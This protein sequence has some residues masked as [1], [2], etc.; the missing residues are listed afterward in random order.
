MPDSFLESSSTSWFGRIGGAIKGMIFGLILLPVSVILLFWNETRAVT[1]A[2]S[3]KEGA[4]AVVSV[5]PDAI[6][7]Q[8][9]QKLIHLSGEVTSGEAVRDPLFGLNAPALRLARHV[10]MYQWKQEEHTEKHKTLGGGEE[11]QTTYNYTKVWSDRPVESAHF[12]HPEEHTNPAA[13]PIPKLTAVTAKA[14]LGAFKIP[15]P[16]IEKM[17]GDEP[18]PATEESLAKLPPPW[19]SKAKLSGDSVYLGSDPNAP[20][21]G[22]ARITFLLLKPGTFSIL[23]QQTGDALAPYP[24]HA[25]REIEDVESGTVSADVMF[26]HDQS[27]NNILTWVLRLA[28]FI[29]MFIGF[30][31]ALNPLHVFADV[32]PFV[33]GIVGFGTGL[34]AALLG[35]A[36]SL[37]VIAIAWLAARPLLGGVLLLVALIALIHTIRR[38]HQ[39]RTPAA[40]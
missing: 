19:K 38:V 39:H 25:G 7:P 22:D 33:G 18:W 36:G 23:A 2:K 5:A 34:V 28:G 3:L 37:V 12:K 8:N 35:L 32:I 1:T 17:Q 26:Q 40:A 10:E 31:A 6:Q 20:A 4:A 24:T 15:A 14:T 30:A 13:F 11:T 21:V 16:I 27:R 29:L 9:D